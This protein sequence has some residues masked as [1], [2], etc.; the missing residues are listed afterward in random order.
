M[1]R[2]FTWLMAFTWELPQTLKA[3]LFML[4]F[5]TWGMNSKSRSNKVVLLW[6]KATCRRCVLLVMDQR[7]SEKAQGL[8]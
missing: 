6:T 8:G 5:R 3:L 2:F 7:V 4:F 1:K